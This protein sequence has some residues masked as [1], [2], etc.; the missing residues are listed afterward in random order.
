VSAHEVLVLAGAYLLGSVPFSYLAGRWK[1][2]DVRRVGSGNVGATNVMRTAGRLPGT[3][4][5]LLDVAKGSA[6]VLLARWAVP[7]S[8][9]LASRAALF[10]VVGH[11]FPFWLGFRGGKGVATGAGALLPLAPGPTGWA[12]VA[13]AVALGVGRYVSVASMAASI[14]LALL[15]FVLGAPRSVALAAAAAAALIVWNHRGNLSR[16]RHGREP[17]LGGPRRAGA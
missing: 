10:A 7:E 1:G 3:A 12:L 16:L 11:T 2:V 15:C 5:L 4:A 8:P 6:A 9:V 14:V 13:F 17:R